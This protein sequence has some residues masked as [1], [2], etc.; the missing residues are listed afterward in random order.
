M[1]LICNC[2][3]PAM[4]PTACSRCSL[5]IGE[6]NRARQCDFMIGPDTTGPYIEHIYTLKSWKKLFDDM[7]ESA[8]ITFDPPV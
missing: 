8:P 5:Y 6:M 4:D 3:L 2:A 1:T 7:K